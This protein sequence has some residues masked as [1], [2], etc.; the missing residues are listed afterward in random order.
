MNSIHRQSEDTI[1]AKWYTRAAFSSRTQSLPN[2]AP[3]I[4]IGLMKTHGKCLP[5]DIQFQPI[6][7]DNMVFHFPLPPSPKPSLQEASPADS[8]VHM[9]DLLNEISNSIEGEPNKKTQRRTRKTAST[10]T[11]RKTTHVRP[12]TLDLQPCDASLSPNNKTPITPDMRSVNNERQQALNQLEHATR[13]VHPNDN[14]QWKPADDIKRQLAGTPE[15]Q[16]PLPLKVG[17]PPAG[18]PAPQKASRN[19][20]INPD[21]HKASDALRRRAAS[22]RRRRP[23]GDS[24]RYS[25]HRKMLSRQHS[26]NSNKAQ[27]LLGIQQQHHHHRHPEKSPIEQLFDQAVLEFQQHSPEIAEEKISQQRPPPPLPPLPTPPP[28]CGKDSERWANRSQRR[29]VLDEQTFYTPGNAWWPTAQVHVSTRSRDGNYHYQN[30]NREVKIGSAALANRL[31]L[32][33]GS[34]AHLGEIGGR[35]R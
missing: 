25:K 22:I 32:P 7:V 33:L 12:P 16:K 1:Q 34:G 23:E 18:R 4:D 11:K 5:F 31:G 27:I 28:S 13:P 10:H 20:E 2:T 30:R 21:F 35:D 14:V 9:P 15:N 19:E 24:D 29:G 3:L 8:A 6:Q 26:L 17:R